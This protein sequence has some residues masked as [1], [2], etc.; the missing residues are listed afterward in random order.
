ML[1]YA[2]ISGR[3]D[4]AELLAR[5]GADV[6]AAEGAPLHG[7]ISF[8]QPA[9]VEW[10]LARGACADRARAGRTPLDVARARGNAAV[11]DLLRRHGGEV[12]TPAV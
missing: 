6:D 3:V 12:T 4:L 10:L 9:M 2:A 8:D 1:Y 7:A 11:I 5:H